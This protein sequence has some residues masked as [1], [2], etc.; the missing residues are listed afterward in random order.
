[1]GMKEVEDRRKRRR[2]KAQYLHTDWE[3]YKSV[4]TLLSTLLSKVAKGWS[5]AR[6]YGA[7]GAKASQGP[8][9]RYL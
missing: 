1:M 2:R 8:A 4:T 6:A 9:R 5:A 7:S 3:I